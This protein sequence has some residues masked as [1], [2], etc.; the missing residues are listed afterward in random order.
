MTFL[1]TLIEK[2]KVDEIDVS[3]YNGI[4]IDFVINH[5]KDGSSGFIFC[6]IDNWVKEI[7]KW[8]RESKI[9]SV[10]VGKNFR[11]FDSKSLDNNYVAIYQLQGTEPG[12]LF[13]IIKDKVLNKNFPEHPWIPIHGVERGAW[14]IGNSKLS[15]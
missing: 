14:K 2:I 1:M 10:L 5:P 8:E 9:D 11:K 15:N 13:K 4:D 12:T 3:F 6:F 7:K